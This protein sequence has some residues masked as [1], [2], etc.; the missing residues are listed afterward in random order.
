MDQIAFIY[1]CQDPLNN[2]PFLNPKL[3]RMQWKFGVKQ[4]FF[5]HCSSTDVP[6]YT[7]FNARQQR[8]NAS[9][10]EPPTEHTVPISDQFAEHIT[11]SRESVAERYTPMPES[12]AK[13][14]TSRTESPALVTAPSPGPASPAEAPSAWPT[15]PA[16]ATN[17]QPSTPARATIAQPTTPVK[18]PSS[19][20][21]TQCNAPKTGPL[22]QVKAPRQQPPEQHCTPHLQPL[23]EDNRQDARARERWTE[24]VDRDTH[25]QEEETRTT[26]T[27]KTRRKRNH[28]QRAKYRSDG[29]AAHTDVQA[30]GNTCNSVNRDGGQEPKQRRAANE[31]RAA[32]NQGKDHLIKQSHS[33]T[34]VAHPSSFF[35]T[36]MDSN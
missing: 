26:E 29:G 34:F 17:A 25:A 21:S 20:P 1:S 6:E 33:F 7:V 18:T 36:C 9:S 23:A 15:S 24:H 30:A 28:R 35:Y 31:N 4:A 8:D 13:H 2:K 27:G 11:E 19:S 14:N 12:P 10:P 22:T 5:L 3:L 16:T 32:S